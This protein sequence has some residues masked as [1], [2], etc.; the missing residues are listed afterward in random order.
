MAYGHP[1]RS[2]VKAFVHRLEVRR[3]HV[4]INLSGRNIGVPKHFLDD[5]KIG[6]PRQQMGRKTMS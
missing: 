1:L 5:S 2:R 6:S 4:G 3:I